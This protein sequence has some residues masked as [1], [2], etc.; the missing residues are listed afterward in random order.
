MTRRACSHRSSLR[1]SSPEILRRIWGR[2]PKCLL[3]R[4][5]LQWLQHC[6]I[7]SSFS[8]ES[9]IFWKKRR[10]WCT[11]LGRNCSTNTFFTRCLISREEII[12]GHTSGWT[13]R[14]L[15]L[16]FVEKMFWKMS[17][18]KNMRWNWYKLSNNVAFW[19]KRQSEVQGNWSEAAFFSKDSFA[20][21]SPIG[22]QTNRSFF[23]VEMHF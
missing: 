6:H 13:L 1:S 21:Y 17:F 3:F 14:S 8:Y 11:F 10:E 16:S 7:N 20:R 4:V 5:F 18:F 12:S 22:S 15:K 19:D 9:C 2:I 23:P